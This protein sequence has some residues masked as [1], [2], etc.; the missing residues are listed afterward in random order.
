MAHAAP[1]RPG[2]ISGAVV[3]STSI[4]TGAADLFPIAVMS[5]EFDYINNDEETTADGD[6]APAYDLSYFCPFRFWF[7]GYMM[8]SSVVTFPLAN[9]ADSTKNPFGA[10]S[11]DAASMKFHLATS[12]VITAPKVNVNRCKILWGRSRAVV[13]LVIIGKTTEVHPTLAST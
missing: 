4:G 2:T 13:G 8:A 12:Q 6:N 3:V 9:L 11:I 7:V 1:A 10:T 5:G